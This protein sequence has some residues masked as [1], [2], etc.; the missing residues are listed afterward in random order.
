MRSKAAKILAVSV[1][2]PPGDLPVVGARVP[3]GARIRQHDPLLEVPRAH[4]HRHPPDAVSP[5][6]NGGDAA[7]HRR[8]I[9]L[10]P[11]RHANGLAFD[12]HGNLLQVLGVHG[13]ARQVRKGAAKRHG[14]RRRPG[15]ARAGGRFAACCHRDVL[16]TV[17]AGR[18]RQQGQVAVRVQLRVAL[19]DDLAIGIKRAE[20]DPALVPWL[21]GNVGAQADGGVDGG[22]AL[23]KEIEGPDV[24]VYRPQ[25]RCESALKRQC[26][27]DG[28]I[29]SGL[30]RVESWTHVAERT[31]SSDRTIAHRRVR[32]LS[33]PR[34]IEGARARVR[35]R[36]RHPVCPQYRRARAGR[37]AVL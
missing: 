37:R 23:V 35:P 2:M 28:I 9:V 29:N 4:R 32:R 34:R 21:D 3:R 27:L 5:E 24:D 17:M 11:G 7:E 16:D 25:D 22:G 30:A 20:L 12:A 31:R 14:Q 19:D 13:R 6:L 36:G 10:D 8:P 33:A 26:A 1:D 15:N 18:K